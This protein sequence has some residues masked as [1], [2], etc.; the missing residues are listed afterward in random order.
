MSKTVLISQSNYI[1]W[2][3]FFDGINRADE[4]II[5]D[6][7]QYTRQDWRNRNRIVTN[8]G[9]K[10]L[11]IPVT[12]NGLYSQT[13]NE[14]RIGDPHW[15]EK[16]WNVI[17]ANYRKAPF[18]ERYRDRFAPL[19]LDNPETYLSRINQQFIE[20][21]N[22][23]LGI[24]TAISRSE[25]YGLRGGKTARLVDL[26]RKAEATHYLSGPA[27]R[28]YL[29]QNLFSEAGIAVLWMNYDGYPEYPQLHDGCEHAVT[30]LDLLFN[31]GPDA[32]GYM[33][34]FPAHDIAKSG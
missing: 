17:T 7:M 27:A 19:Y 1:P 31:T 12:V 11:T 4:F 25:D 24:T 16:H 28:D 13:I 26:C 23:I 6:E 2:K 15:G 10:W 29:D 21:V 9:V 18:F 32:P 22:S 30:I 20:T 34:S 5:Y 14:T 3:G 33:K 8:G